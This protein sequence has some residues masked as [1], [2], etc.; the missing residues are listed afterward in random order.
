MRSA[1]RQPRRAVRDPLFKGEGPQFYAAAYKHNQ[2]WAT[3]GP[4][5]YQTKLAP[6]EEQRFRGWLQNHNDPGGFNPNAEH[7]DYD[8]RGFWRKYHGT[9]QANHRPGQH[10]TDEFKTP[11]DTSFSDESVYA[12]PGTPFVWRTNRNGNGILIN[13]RNGRLIL[14]EAEE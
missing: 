12:K 10:F 8:M 11:F 7:V 6:G 9:T 4:S 2:R 1:T 13:R 3:P 5:G 14:R